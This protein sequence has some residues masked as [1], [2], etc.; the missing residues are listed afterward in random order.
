MLAQ[1]VSILT[2]AFICVQPHRAAGMAVNYY[3]K[4]SLKF[5]TKLDFSLN[6]K[7][8]EISTCRVSFETIIFSFTNYLGQAA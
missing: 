6:C 7:V 3:Y 1:H 8:N 4:L 5:K 2:L